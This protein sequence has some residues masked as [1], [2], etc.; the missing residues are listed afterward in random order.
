MVSAPK[1]KK[2]RG[3]YKPRDKAPAHQAI[4]AHPSRM[5]PLS[6]LRAFEAVARL[7][8]QRLEIADALGD[9]RFDAHEKPRLRPMPQRQRRR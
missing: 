5:P 6:T 1:T 3:Q 7:Q 2:A 9:E 8:R 4:L